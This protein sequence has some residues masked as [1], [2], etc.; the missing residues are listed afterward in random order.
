MI[1]LSV[2][3]ENFSFWNLALETIGYLDMSIN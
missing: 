2:I 1:N 3:F